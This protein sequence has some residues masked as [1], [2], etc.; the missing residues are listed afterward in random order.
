MQP[1]INS[2]IF[3]CALMALVLI[4]N[5]NDGRNQSCSILRVN[6]FLQW[7]VQIHIYL[8]LRHLEHDDALVL[9]GKS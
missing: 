7:P 5:D 6:I 9:V 8:Q 3:L 2:S 4:L 1:K